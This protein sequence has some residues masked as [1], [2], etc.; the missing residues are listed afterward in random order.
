MRKFFFLRLQVDF[1]HAGKEHPKSHALSLDVSSSYP[2]ILW[3]YR[4]L[5]H[6]PMGKENYSQEIDF[7]L[8]WSVPLSLRWSESCRELQQWLSCIQVGFEAIAKQ[9]HWHSVFGSEPETTEASARLPNHLRKGRVSLEMQ[10]LIRCSDLETYDQ[11]SNVRISLQRQWAN[12]RGCNGRIIS[13]VCKQK[14]E[15]V[16][17]HQIS[18]SLPFFGCA[19][20]GSTYTRRDV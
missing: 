7:E 19:C 9:S 6:D 4:V 20:M 8:W 18:F 5:G 16:L 12:A 13:L 1:L 3:F 14:M 11:R 15:G 10:H 17:N 2:N